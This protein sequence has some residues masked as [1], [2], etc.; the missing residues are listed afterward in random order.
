[1]K[2]AIAK[3]M[4]I[5]PPAPIHVVQWIA[6]I[7][8]LKSECDPGH[9]AA[10]EQY[11]AEIRQTHHAAIDDMHYLRRIPCFKEG[12]I[13]MLAKA[14]HGTNTYE[15]WSCMKNHLLQIGFNM[16]SGEAPRNKK[17]RELAK[18]VDQMSA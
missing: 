10:L 3:G 1:M 14:E 8:A 17:E 15:A 6:A 13:K 9:K 5:T 11:A 18:M 16:M 4:K 12:D 7:E 2:A